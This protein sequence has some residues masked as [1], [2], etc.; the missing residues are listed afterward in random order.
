MGNAHTV[1]R[2]IIARWFF[3]LFSAS[4]AVWVSI[5][6]FHA[7]QSAPDQVKLVNYDEL[8]TKALDFVQQGAERFFQM[9]ILILGGVWTLGVVDKDQRVKLVDI[10][11]LVMFGIA[12]SLFL[13]EF[14]FLQQ[15][16]GIL[17]HV[18]WDVRTLTGDQGQKLFPNIL[19]SPYLDLHYSVVVKCFFSGLTVSG[20]TVLS[21]CRLR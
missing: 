17:E 10:P 1:T 9:G 7:F 2:A 12:T 8:A 3:A 5:S 15:Y 4:L 16:D 18:V 11:E 14:Y 6:V 19:Q 13:V 20:L 21:L